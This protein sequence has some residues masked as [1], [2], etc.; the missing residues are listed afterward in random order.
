PK[1]QVTTSVGSQDASNVAPPAPPTYE[2]SG[3]QAQSQPSIQGTGSVE[4]KAPVE[5]DTRQKPSYIADVEELQADNQY[6]SSGHVHRGGYVPRGGRGGY[7]PRGGAHTWRG[8][9][10]GRGAYQGR[11]GSGRPVEIPE[12]DFDF[13]SS[14][15]KLNKDD[16]AKEFAKLNVQVSDDTNSNVMA[17]PAVVAGPSTSAVATAA[18]SG[19]NTGAYTQKSFFDDISCEAKERLQMQEFGLSYEERRNR[20]QAERQ[21]NYETFGQATSDQAQL[22]YNRFQSNRGRGGAGAQN[23]YYH[24]SSNPNYNS[25]YN[26]TGSNWRGGR[27]GRGGYQRG[28][29]RNQQTRDL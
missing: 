19:S 20:F 25:G 18:P 9:R 3:G 5:A 7:V 11:H 6:R 23:G 22:R 13:E 24:S 26:N 14:N 12:S 21:Q 8:A 15:S 16:L 1:A 10:G 4:T 28:G 17:P 2:G 29:Y 27:G